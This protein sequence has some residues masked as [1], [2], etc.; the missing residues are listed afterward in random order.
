V[1]TIFHVKSDS[2]FLTINEN[3]PLWK[4]K[5]IYIILTQI[6]NQTLELQL[7]LPYHLPIDLLL[8]AKQNTKN[9]NLFI[10]GYLHYHKFNE[11]FNAI[12][13][14]ED[15]NTIMNSSPCTLFD[16]EYETFE[17]GIVDLISDNPNEN[18]IKI[19]ENII[20]SLDKYC[21][22]YDGFILD[23]ILTNIDFF[24]MKKIYL[25]IYVENSLE[26]DDYLYN[27]KNNWDNCKCHAVLTMFKSLSVDEWKIVFKNM[28][29][30]SLFD[31]ITFYFINGREDVIY[32]ACG[33][34]AVLPTVLINDLD[35]LKNSIVVPHNEISG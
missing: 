17:E 24:D 20:L 34:N 28:T 9:T 23:Q 16:C 6:I 21:S 10:M 12:K 33:R 2:F 31:L 29:G 3:H 25:K 11:S 5:N 8:K 30:T 27:E 7:K 4:N 14:M 22:H 1:N 19:I 32:C 15:I 26:Y 35:F 18:Q 13:K